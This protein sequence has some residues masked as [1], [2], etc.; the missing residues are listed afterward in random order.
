MKTTVVTS[1]SA[2]LTLPS[3]LI[4][5]VLICSCSPRTVASIAQTC[6]ALHTL[7]Y[8]SPDSHLWRELFLT[9]WDDPRPALQHRSLVDPRI[10]PT[11]WDWA[12]EYRRRVSA[13]KWLKAWR[14]DIYLTDEET[15][16][17]GKDVH[18]DLDTEWYTT[19]LSALSA[20]LNTLL[21]LRP[22]PATP[23]IALTVLTPAISSYPTGNIGS[24]VP[25]DGSE[26]RERMTNAPPLPPLLF[27]F[28]SGL[29]LSYQES[30]SGVRV[31]RMVY[32]P[33][34]S[35]AVVA[36][37]PTLIPTPSL[38][39][40]LVRT[41][42][43]S[44]M[45]EVRGLPGHLP[46]LSGA[47]E[48]GEDALGDV[49]HRI[50][51]ITGFVPIPPPLVATTTSTSTS[52]FIADDARSAA[53]DTEVRKN[54][55][56]NTRVEYERR[57]LGEEA[58]GEEHEEHDRCESG[59]QS[60]ASTAFPTPLQ[61]RADARTLARRR[62]YDM[63]YLRG[64][65]LWGPFQIVTRE[66]LGARPG[67]KRPG[68][69]RKEVPRKGGRGASTSGAPSGRA[70]PVP[71][72]GALRLGTL[73]WAIGVD[74]EPDDFDS[75]SDDDQ[76]EDWRDPA[77]TGKEP[78]SSSE[79]RE[80]VREQTHGG[81]DM[82]DGDSDVEPTEPEHPLMS[83]I[84]SSPV[85]ADADAEP[86]AS[87]ASTTSRRRTRRSNPRLPRNSLISPRQIK[88]EHLR[89]DYAYLA[90]VRIVVEA[91]LRELFG[92]E[93]S[94]DVEEA[95]SEVRAGGVGMFWEDEDEM[96][97]ARAGS[98]GL[99]I[100]LFVSLGCSCETHFDSVLCISRFVIIYYDTTRH[101]RDQFQF[102]TV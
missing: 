91:N 99:S 38:P 20:V 10:D 47:D 28:A 41:L 8:G 29:D 34:A 82:V 95:A 89:P 85:I 93:S 100:S 40:Q 92:A 79:S 36:P 9:I 19:T 3:E 53:V 27:V 84:L 24:G 5:A 52:E 14:R 75:T 37:T 4:E 80:R 46:F 2:L 39:P 6:R 83:L 45:V 42:F 11:G 54:Q 94:D 77:D 87:T 62:V 66:A 71:R 57:R 23:P 1:P 31:G 17:V 16:V 33:H 88:P 61:Q 67:P 25:V 90:S 56:R 60:D 12:T 81:E 86:A 22:F 18:T 48:W 74:I 43:A 51:C 50:V 78:S 64:D 59:E 102:Y 49:F 101:P 70:G 58:F 98:G 68:L 30:R 21:T 35:R 76:D 63:R 72:L 97:G 96:L 15:P 32:G 26:R 69:D 65:R 44:R 7:V 55:Q 73:A 13:D